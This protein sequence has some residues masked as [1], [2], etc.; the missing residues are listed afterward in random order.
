MVGPVGARN[1]RADGVLLAIPLG[2]P[3]VVGLHEPGAVGGHE[4]GDARVRAAVDARCVAVGMQLG[5]PR[6]QEREHRRR[7]R[8]AGRVGLHVVI[9]RV[10]GADPL[11]LGL[12]DRVV[13]RRR[14]LGRRLRGD[15]RRAPAPVLG[16]LQADV[17]REQDPAGRRLP[18]DPPGTEIGLRAGLVRSADVDPDRAVGRRAPGRH[19]RAARR[20]AGVEAEAGEHRVAG[21][22]DRPRTR[23]GGLGGSLRGARGLA[24]GRPGRARRQRADPERTL[25]DRRIA[26]P[27]C[28]HLHSRGRNRERGG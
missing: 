2:D 20:R 11:G 24:G 4:V 12:V 18:V 6:G 5:R 16:R 1:R 15:D 26:L 21:A 7:V 23:G 28:R 3:D 22:V 19:R 17:D 8:V 10:A 13:G 9:D 27:R 25:D 14:A